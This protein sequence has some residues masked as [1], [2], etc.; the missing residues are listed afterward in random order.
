M[1]LKQLFNFLFRADKN[2]SEVDATQLKDA[3][4]Q[5]RT[6]LRDESA[7]SDQTKSALFEWA[8]MINGKMG[9]ASSQ[10]EDSSIEPTPPDS[11]S[12]SADTETDTEPVEPAPTPDLR[13]VPE[14]P[15][16]PDP[17][18]Y[19]ALSTTD[20]DANKAVLQ[21]ALWSGADI[22]I[23][24]VGTYPLTPPVI[25]TSQTLDLNGATIIMNARK[26]DGALFCLTGENPAIQNGSIQGSFDEPAVPVSSPDFF[27]KESLVGLYPYGYSNAHVA[28]VKLRRAWGYAICERTNEESA[29]LVG[30]PNGSLSMA[31]RY[32]VYLDRTFE[33]RE[34][35]PGYL[36]GLMA[37]DANRYSYTTAELDLTAAQ[38]SIL[39]HMSGSAETYRYISASNGL[40]YFRIISDERITYTFTVPS[41]TP[42]VKTALQGEAVEIPDGATSVCLTTYCKKEHAAQW[43]IDDDPASDVGYVIYL[44]NYR[45]GLDVHDCEM[46][47]NS[48]LGM[49]GTS[50]GP[51]YVKNC[52]SYGNGRLDE[53]SGPA[54]TTVGFIDVEDNPTCFVS[55]ENIVSDFETNGAMLGA[56]TAHVK[57]WR[58]TTVLIYRG[59]SA[60]VEDS[61]GYIGLFSDDVTTELT[62]KNSIIRGKICNKLSNYVL[63][64]NCTFYNCSVR[65][66]NDSDSTYIYTNAYSGINNEIIGHLKTDIVTTGGLSV[67]ALSLQKDSVVSLQT[68][69]K[70]NTL[71]GH[72]S[73]ITATGD[74]YGLR[75]NDTIYPDGHMICDAVIKPGI[76][77]HPAKA[78]AMYGV[79]KN[80]IFDL[81]QREFCTI[82][83]HMYDKTVEFEGCTIY[84]K[85][86][87]LFAREGTSPT[88]V[89]QGTHLIFRNC[90]IDS[91]ANI[92][93]TRANTPGITTAGEPQIE[94]INCIFGEET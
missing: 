56:V 91:K 90:T 92:C 23:A 69:G 42:V 6:A 62:I 17:F 55:L 35:K 57:N 18:Q 67:R 4:A 39:P 47:F 86:H 37:E 70:E 20:G 89:G 74:C 75:V 1:S 53:E 81:S 87:M 11:D 8:Q 19:I 36:G 3:L 94:F 26:Y 43:K 88:G 38:S 5:L 44:S 64:R 49:C 72:W 61:D 63:T 48:S 79:F 24:A 60:I 32:Y 71:F 10:V 85:D 82:G 12:D 40:G 65:T 84:N 33:T 80:C 83:K 50:L 14:A 13:P 16:E 27:E 52:I 7:L 78:D 54:Q 29:Q 31:A 21:A 93:M 66:L 9:G 34:S 45:G 28:N 77:R 22:K 46:T 73:P 30:L 51:T 41:T 58:G 15:T 2:P 68:N 76:Y 25:I 59:L